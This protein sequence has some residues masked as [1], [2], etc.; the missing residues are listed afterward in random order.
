MNPKNTWQTLGSHTVYK[1][2]WIR[3]R[4]DKV[5]KPNGRR[6]IYGVVESPPSVYIVALSNKKEIYPVPSRIRRGVQYSAE[7]CGI[8]LI[9]QYRYPTKVWSWEIPSGGSDG[10]PPMT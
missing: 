1:N 10:Q 7:R 8:Y 2:K 6:G 3:V 5:I 4:E 9:K